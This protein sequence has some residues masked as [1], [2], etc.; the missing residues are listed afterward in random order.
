M[1]GP[2]HTFEHTAEHHAGSGSGERHVDAETSSNYGS[3]LCKS[4]HLDWKWWTNGF[5]WF[6]IEEYIYSA[7]V[8]LTKISILLLYLR[9]FPETERWFRPT[10][11]LLMGATAI[12]AIPVYFTIVFQCKPIA[13]TWY[14]DLLPMFTLLMKYMLSLYHEDRHKWDALQTGSCINTVAQIATLAAVNMILDMVIILLPVPR[15]LKLNISLGKKIGVIAVFTMGLFVTVTSAVR[16]QYVV[17]WGE[18]QNPTWQYNPLALWSSIECNS[19]VICACMPPL[20][21]PF[22]RVFKGTIVKR[23]FS[24]DSEGA[25]RRR[26]SNSPFGDVQRRFKT[27]LVGAKSKLPTFVTVQRGYDSTDELE[28]VDRNLGQ[29]N[30]SV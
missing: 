14:V 17:H 6:W 1:L 28:L 18:S 26:P 30:S 7:L 9:L 4:M 2:A 24:S 10:C 25:V 29:Q 5:Q 27:D 13:Y 11:L 16:L 20:A 12:T 23:F 15:L 21:G 22:K 19:T 8:L 3:A